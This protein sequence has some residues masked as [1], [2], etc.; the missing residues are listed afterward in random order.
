M[1]FLV[2]ISLIFF[3]VGSLDFYIIYLFLPY[4]SNFFLNFLTIN[5]LDFIFLFLFFGVMG[6]SAQ[7]GLHV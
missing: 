3:Y 4:F 5:L 7:I 1:G 2:A 6:K